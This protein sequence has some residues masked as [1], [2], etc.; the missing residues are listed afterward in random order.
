MVAKVAFLATSLLLGFNQPSEVLLTITKPAEIIRAEVSAYT[1]SLDETDSDHN[2]TAS[3]KQAVGNMVAC[4]SR[5][6]FGTIVEIKGKKYICE[7]R[8][9]RRYRNGNYFDILMETKKEA[10]QWGR[11]TVE[12]T[13]LQNEL[14][15]G[16][17]KVVDRVLSNNI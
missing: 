3:G 16:S 2:T 8:M 14:S 9:A 6:P 15:T 12:V 10:R 7:D 11:R 1:A 4:P 5:Y 17:F 13:I